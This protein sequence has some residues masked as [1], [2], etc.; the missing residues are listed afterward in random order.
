MCIVAKHRIMCYKNY[1]ISHQLKTGICTL[2]KKFNIIVRIS[3][4]DYYILNSLAQDGIDFLN[5]FSR[6]MRLI[7][8]ISE[9]QLT[10]NDVVIEETN[11]NVFSRTVLVFGDSI[12]LNLKYSRG[13]SLW[14]LLHSLYKQVTSFEF[15][16]ELPSSE[17]ISTNLFK[18]EQKYKINY[19]KYEKTGILNIG[20]RLYFEIYCGSKLGSTFYLNGIHITG[21]LK[22]NA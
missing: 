6:A 3:F 15:E 22:Q 18:L 14:V 2:T 12:N 8:F 10:S 7:R 13:I 1:V 21:I 19:P 9:E 11:A 5:S 16:L 4:L 17:E 20:L